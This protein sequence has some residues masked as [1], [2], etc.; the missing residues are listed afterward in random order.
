MT[1]WSKKGSKMITLSP[2]LRNARNALS[3]PELILVAP[4]EGCFVYWTW[5]LP[6]TNLHWRQLWQWCQIQ[7]PT[8]SQCWWIG[9][10]KGLP[11]TQP[12]LDRKQR[13]SHPHERRPI[14]PTS[15]MVIQRNN[16]RCWDHVPTY[17]QHVARTRADLKETIR[18][19]NLSRELAII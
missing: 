12:A 19:L 18:L 9:L 14:T 11:Q 4:A 5:W 3:M 6:Q 8:S 2:G 17:Q 15:I 1:Y 13:V 10:S 7:D 16:E